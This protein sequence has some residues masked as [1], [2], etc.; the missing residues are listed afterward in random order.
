MI[1]VERSQRIDYIKKFDYIL[2]G[3]VFL[4]TAIGLVFLD[5]AMYS[6]FKDHGV[7]SMRIQIMGLVIGVIA[8]I[9]IDLLGIV[10]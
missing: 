10:A 8:G 5:S 9:I 7:A 1:D 4:L 6:A 2:L 3:L